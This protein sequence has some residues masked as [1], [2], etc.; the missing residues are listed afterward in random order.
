[1][2]WWVGQHDVPRAVCIHVG[3]VLR[4]QFCQYCRLTPCSAHQPA[5]CVTTS[6]VLQLRALGTRLDHTQAVGGW[7]HGIRSC[8]MET[9]GVHGVRGMMHGT[10]GVHALQCAMTCVAGKCASTVFGLWL[11][12]HVGRRGNN[13]G[14]G[15]VHL[16]ANMR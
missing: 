15:W 3:H 14:V 9:S 6:A 8:V 12:V 10:Y 16:S 11:V 7:G 13:T 4:P 1:M 2:T 5:M